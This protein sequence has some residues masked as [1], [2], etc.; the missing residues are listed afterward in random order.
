MATLD[1]KYRAVTRLLQIVQILNV[2]C[3]T[4][5]IRKLWV[6]RTESGA[7]PLRP[8]MHLY[9]SAEMSSFKSSLLKEAQSVYKGVYQYGLTYASLVGSIDKLSGELTESVAWNARD[10]ILFVD[11][12]HSQ[13]ERKGDLIKSFL[14]LLSDQQYSRSIGLKSVT[15]SRSSNGNSYKIHNGR[16]ELKVRFA[17]I[18]ASM[19]SLKMF[20]KYVS[21]AALLD[22]CIAIQYEVTNEDRDAVARGKRIFDF[23]PYSCPKEVT[24]ERKD[25]ERVYDFWKK[26][27]REIHDNRALDD[28]LRA[29]AVTQEHSEDLYRFIIESHAGLDEIKGE[30]KQERES[31]QET[32]QRRY[33]GRPYR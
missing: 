18:F 29:Y 30:I 27:S 2:A 11:E 25:F 5:P 24:V 1:T 9:L 33:Y 7:L 28:C 4:A 12:F 15:K 14:P 20:A 8:Q 26:G 22:R 21:H 17:A 23:T 3:S 16:I 19:Y 32:H 31:K 13:G 6:D 10:S